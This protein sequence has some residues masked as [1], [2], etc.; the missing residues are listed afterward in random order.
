[1]AG[2]APLWDARPKVVV[3]P[4]SQLS[5]RRPDFRLDVMFPG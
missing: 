5:E 1:M 2:D 3:R 4:I